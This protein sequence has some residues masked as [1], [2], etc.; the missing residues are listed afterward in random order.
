MTDNVIG[1][2]SL[3]IILPIFYICDM[4]LVICYMLPCIVAT[5]GAAVLA[6]RE[7]R[8]AMAHDLMSIFLFLLAICMACTAQLFSGRFLHSVWFDLTSKCIAPLCVSL[9]ILFIVSLTSVDGISLRAVLASLAAPALYAAALVAVTLIL[10]A[11]ERQIYMAQVVQAE[12]LVSSPSMRLRLMTLLGTKLYSVL[13]PAFTVSALAWSAFRLRNYYRMLND[14]YASSSQVQRAYGWALLLI[15]AVFIPVAAFLVFVPHYASVPGW[16]PWTLVL[17]ECVLLVLVT[18]VAYVLRFTA[19]DLR[20]ALESHRET[21]PRESVQSQTKQQIADLLE[22]AINDRKVYLDPTLSVISFAQIIGTNRTYLQ[23]VIKEQYE[24]TF[25]EYINRCRV[26]HAKD[27]L[28]ADPHMPLKDV[29]V[30]SGFNSLSSF[31]RNF[32]EF[33]NRTPAQW[34]KELM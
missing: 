29:A 14:F 13:L 17:M 12:G 15:V 25:S 22:A 31:H 2:L 5:L 32:Q 23:S 33:E 8:S 9:Y 28:T 1:P 7:P 24:C 26:R 16:V 3:W 27:L 18:S 19:A 11:D 21:I 10:Q 34:V 30:Q 4:N 6:L 20:A